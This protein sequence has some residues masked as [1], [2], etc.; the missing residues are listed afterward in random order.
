MSHEHA[1]RKIVNDRL[2][3]IE[4]QLRGIRKMVEED[5]DCFEVLKQV[6]ATSGALRSLG[7]LI[8]ED[9]LDGCVNEALGGKESNEELLAQIVDAFKKFSR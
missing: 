4:G 2:N 1:N 3:R 6:A 9:H 7:L 5:R 8:L